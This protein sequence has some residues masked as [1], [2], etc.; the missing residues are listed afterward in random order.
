MNISNSVIWFIHIECKMGKIIS[1]IT[2][3][4]KI[5][6]FFYHTICDFS[7][8]KIQPKKSQKPDVL[9]KNRGQIWIQHRKLL[10]K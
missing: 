3:V 6:T 8:K 2:L 5:F 4:N 10:W 7:K 9:G 1:P